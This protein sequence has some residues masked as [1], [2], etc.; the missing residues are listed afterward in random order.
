M[1]AQRP[2]PTG[3]ESVFRESEIIVSKT[4][5]QGR[6]TY[7]NDVFARVSGYSERELIGAPHSLV[8]HPE[9][10]R[11]VF[12]L[13]WDTIQKRQEVFAYVLNMARNG[14]HYWV[15]AHVTASYDLRGTHVG[16]HSN[17]RLPHA[18]AVAKVKPLYGKL[19]AVEQ[20]QRDRR[21]SVEAGTQA[22]ASTLSQL[23][24]SYSQFLFGLSSHTTLEG[25][26]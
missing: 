16:Y 11:C 23:G 1:S 20:A 7:A 19:L 15:L 5:L 10:P 24:L 8:R 2:V 18:D 22:L 13:L 9:M 14:D 26:A 6:I 25:V 12:K 21:A 17:R 3:R 4:D